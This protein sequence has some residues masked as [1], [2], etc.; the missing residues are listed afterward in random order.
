M[1]ATIL[2]TG[3]TGASA[4]AAIGA[5]AVDYSIYAP[6]MI[7]ALLGA[8]TALMLRPPQGTRLMLARFWG[9][10][11]FGFIL[12]PNVTAISWMEWL[13]I[14]PDEN[15][16]TLDAGPA[17]AAFVLF[18]LLQVAAEVLS[19]PSMSGAVRGLLDKFTGGK[20]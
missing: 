17:I 20:K 7:L 9:G 11:F 13:K 18:F 12:G 16:F 15:G 4:G 10:S 8:G 1:K 19:S 14:A 2:A 3:A 5:A 6:A